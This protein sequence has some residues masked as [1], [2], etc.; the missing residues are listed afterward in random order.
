MECII[1]IQKHNLRYCIV[2]TPLLSMSK[3]SGPHDEYLY[4]I[5]QNTLYGDSKK[6]NGQRI[7]TC[8]KY[9]FVEVDWFESQ[10]IFRWN[11]RWRHQMETVSALL[12]ICVGNSTVPG[13]FPAQRLVT[14]SF[15]LFFDLRP[16]K[17]LSKQSRGWWFETPSCPLWRHRNSLFLSSWPKL[18]LP[19]LLMCIFCEEESDV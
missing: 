15:D 4:Y 6:G 18:S 13:E 3:C 5:L 14:R 10:S 19:Q 8:Q 16:N 11:A 17:R 1:A 9:N 12:A 2:I 7:R